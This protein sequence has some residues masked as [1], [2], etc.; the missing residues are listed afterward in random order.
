MSP[1]LALKRGGL[2]VPVGESKPVRAQP[3]TAGFWPADA[4]AR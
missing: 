2:A 3:G 1:F 4:S